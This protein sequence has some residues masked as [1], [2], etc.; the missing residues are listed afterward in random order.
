MQFP[1]STAP[2]LSTPR[3]ASK[4]SLEPEP[5]QPALPLSQPQTQPQ[6]QSSSSSISSRPAVQH[7]SAKGK[8]KQEPTEVA[9][10]D[11]LREIKED[12]AAAKQKQTVK[13]LD[14]HLAKLPDRDRKCLM[15]EISQI[16]GIWACVYACLPLLAYPGGVSILYLIS[17]YIVLKMLNTLF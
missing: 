8:R 12:I 6:I 5:Q 14:H 4:L 16:M 7:P 11:R 13:Y 2:C 3:R 1:C 9:I 15:R 10:P 17:G